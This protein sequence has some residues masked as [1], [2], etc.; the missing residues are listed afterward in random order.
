MDDD[1]TKRED[2]DS[3]ETARVSSDTV[4]E[5]SKIPTSIGKY[6][7][8]T[9]LGEGGMGVVYEAEQDSPKRKVAVKVVRGGQF[10]DEQRVRMFQREADTLARLKHPNIGGI[11]ESGRTEDGQHFFA[12]ELVRGKTLDRYIKDRPKAATLEELHHRL[13]LFRKIGD[14]V[15]YAHQR[16]VIHRDL[17]PSN[18]VVTDAGAGNDSITSASKLP[19]IKILDF[20]LA[21]ITEGDTAATHSMSRVGDIKGTLAYMSPEQARGDP[22]EIDVRTDVYALGMILYEMLSGTRPYDVMHKAL[23]E[24]VLVISEEPP[25]SLKQ[26]ISGV[27][28]IDPDIETIVGKALEKEAD[29]RYSSAAAL[30]EDIGRY[31]TSQPILARPPSAIYQ[32]RKFTARNR[33][34]VGGIAATFIVL[35]VGIVVSTTLGLREAEQRREAEEQRREAERARDDLEVVVDFQA[36]MLDDLEPDQM[37]RRLMENLSERVA[38]AAKRRGASEAGVEGSL[39]SFKE[40]MLGVNAT[41]AALQVLDEDILGRAA[42]VIDERFADRPLIDARLRGTIGATYRKLG[43]YERAEPQLEAALAT[44]KRVLGDEHPDTLIYMYNLAI[45]Y[46]EQGRYAEAESLFLETVETHKRVLGDEY[47]STLASM[48]GLAILYENQGRYDEAEPLYLEILETKK[49][50]LGD[51]HPSTLQSM[52]GLAILY[53]S[54]G[55]YAEAESLFLEFHEIQRHVLGDEHPSTLGAMNN[56]A[57]LY[58]LQGRYAEA[59][60]MYRENLATKKRVLGDEHPSVGSTIHNLA[61]LYRDKEQYDESQRYFERAQLIWEAKL[62][63]EHPYVAE[64]LE[65][66]AALLRKSGDDDGADRMEARARAIRGK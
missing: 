66:W 52:H 11:Y 16:G 3:T 42:N 48:H 60:A 13:R 55:R 23:P 1:K 35:V 28:R 59:E 54:Q 18:I 22:D 65:E 46:A 33:A 39:A 21:R 14:A 32:L 58:K 45:L 12:M 50:V 36:G 7:I 6:R 57:I 26:T 40:S 15:H 56:L 43:R 51:E 19:E 44:R 49:R 37:G 5:P 24:A 17:K 61:C 9:K 34:L 64:N 27:R 4:S 53:R 31:L 29:R 63:G 47:P 62:G 2:M 30:S 41:D 38:K 10:V 25:K 8:L 20:G